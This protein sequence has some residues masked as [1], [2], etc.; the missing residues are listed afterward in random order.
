[1]SEKV[2]QT[3]PEVYWA[4]DP[5]TTVE[6]ERFKNTAVIHWPSKTPPAE[7]EGC[8][9][10]ESREQ[11]TKSRMNCAFNLG[12]AET[13]WLAMVTL[14]YR[15]NPE[16]YEVTKMHRTKF[17]DRLRKAY[18]GSHVAWFLEFTEKGVAHYHLFLGSGGELGRV[19]ADSPIE[20]RTRRET[21]VE[22]VRGAVD[23]EIVGW[24]RDLT[25]DQ[26]D[27]WE[28]FQTGGIIDKCRHPDAAGRYAAKEAAKRA[29]KRAPWPVKQ[30]WGMSRNCRP[31]PRKKELQT[32]QKLHRNGLGR[33]ISRVWDGDKILDLNA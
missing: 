3:I 26:S 9:D 21:P 22:V 7:S 28:A 6:V 31:K 19:L 24:W 29:Q 5:A 17:L 16:S 32:L 11:S 23:E 12:N 33:V 1:M 27:E 2:W 25:S 4:F 30:W 20:K 8:P 18:P 10:R 13:E 15:K 14:T